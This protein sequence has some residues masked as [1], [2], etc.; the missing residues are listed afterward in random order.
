MVAKEAKEEKSGS[1]DIRRDCLR[2]TMFNITISRIDLV[3]KPGF[4]LVDD[5]TPESARQTSTL[6]ENNARSHLFTAT[7]NDEC[8]DDEGVHISYSQQDEGETFTKSMCLSL[9]VQPHCAPYL[10]LL[11]CGWL[12]SY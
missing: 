6:L 9:P 12:P 11:S 1:L 7:E 3:W 10:N 8:E 2:F 4:V 5:L